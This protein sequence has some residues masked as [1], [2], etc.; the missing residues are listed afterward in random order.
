M[1][2][3]PQ[4]LTRFLAL[5]CF[6]VGL[7]GLLGSPFAWQAG[8]VAGFAFILSTL[9]MLLAIVAEWRD[10]WRVKVH[11]TREGKHGNAGS[12]TGRESEA[13]Q[14]QEPPSDW[15]QI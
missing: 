8:H 4:F 5:C 11:L 6:A 3:M 12:N 2:P 15:E 1:P 7:V 9:L 14:P 10:E 13:P